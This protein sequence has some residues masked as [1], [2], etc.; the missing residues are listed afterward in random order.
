MNIPLSTRLFL[1]VTDV[2]SYFE[3]PVG[4]PP[5]DHLELDRQET[6]AELEAVLNCSRPML[7]AMEAAADEIARVAPHDAVDILEAC[8]TLALYGADASEILSSIEG[9]VD[10]ATIVSEPPV[11]VAEYASEAKSVYG[12][13]YAYV[14][15]ATRRDLI[16]DSVTLDDLYQGVMVDD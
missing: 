6:I 9:V 13:S 8:Q 2:R 14:C 3:A 7:A 5:R 11:A 16:G 15:D 1:F 10:L 4:R 12:E